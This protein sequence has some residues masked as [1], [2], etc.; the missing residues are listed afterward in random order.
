M[1]PKWSIVAECGPGMYKGKK[2]VSSNVYCS[3]EVDACLLCPGTKIKSV[4]GDSLSLCQDVCDGAT[5][6]PNAARTACGELLSLFKVLL[7]SKY[8]NKVINRSN[9]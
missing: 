2:T 6:V 5:N 9:K 1:C 8:R 7:S 3:N 4:S